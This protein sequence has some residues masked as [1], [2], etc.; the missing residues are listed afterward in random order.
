M[1]HA[2]KILAFIPLI[3][4]L[5][6][7]SGTPNGGNPS[8]GVTDAVSIFTAPYVVLD[9]ATGTLENRAAIPDLTS[10]SLWRT[11]KLVFHRLPSSSGTVGAASAD[12]GTDLGD[13]PATGL[14]VGATF[15]AVFETTQQQ[16]TTLGGSAAWLDP[17]I[18]AAGG[19]IVAAGAPAYGI[20]WTAANELC[21]SYSAGRSF[22]VALPNSAA[23]ELACRSGNGGGWFSW[24]NAMDEA[25][26]RSYAAV[27]ETQSGMAG[28]RQADGSRL[29]NAF[30][31]YDLHGN[32]WEW[33][34]EKDSFGDGL[35]CGG[36]WNDSVPLARCSNR[37][38]LDP[39]V[40]H[41]LIGVRLVLVP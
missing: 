29:A 33:L 5:V 36:S 38:S 30:G 31:Y 32:V 41:P 40:T 8:G 16:W 11:S 9:L 13:A 21:T 34:A 39:Q 23:W 4:S 14:T 19:D 20:S 24:G 35:I 17:E 25:T 1:R 22:H 3:A 12:L 2:N 37:I 28:P 18:R 10:N 27:F 15:M 7:C 6:G 26:V